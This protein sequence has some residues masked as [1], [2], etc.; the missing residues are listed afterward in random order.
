VDKIKKYSNAIIQVLEEFASTK[1]ANL[2]DVQS[3]IVCDTKNHH[4]LLMRV[5]WNKKEYVHHC[6]IHFD[7]IDNKV[8]L[9]QNWSDI[10]IADRLVELG[11]NKSDIVLGFEPDFMRPFSGFAVA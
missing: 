1:P 3:Q 4:Y 7:I 11:V 5:G 8:W 10:L 2:P 9:Q 6:M